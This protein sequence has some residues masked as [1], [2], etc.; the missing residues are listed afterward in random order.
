VLSKAPAK[1]EQLGMVS[2]EVTPDMRWDEKGDANKVFEALKRRAAEKGAN[3]LLLEVP[4]PRMS[5][6]ATAGYMGTFYQ[7]PVMA[8][9]GQRTAMAQAVYVVED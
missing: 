7:I 9:D 1:Y 5:G 6:K 3:G 4:E 8:K 2:V